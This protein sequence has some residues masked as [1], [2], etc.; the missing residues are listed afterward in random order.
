MTTDGKR[1][2][3]II[4][5]TVCWL[6]G[7]EITV[8]RQPIKLEEK[9]NYLYGRLSHGDELARDSNLIINQRK[10][11]TKYSED[12]VDTDR[13]ENDFTPMM[14]LFNEWFVKNTSK[15]IRAVF[16][17]KGKSGERLAVIPR[18]GSPL[19]GNRNADTR[20]CP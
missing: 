9:I 16:Q 20:N 15:K 14:N 5:I 18:Y 10:I 1:A 17:S 13:G 12:N 4:Y 11:L 3:I 19:Y 7:M 8:I 6:S 2:I